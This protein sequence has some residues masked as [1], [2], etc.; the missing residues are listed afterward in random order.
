VP[1]ALRQVFA[2]SGVLA[3]E[4]G[5]KE[6]VTIRPGKRAWWVEPTAGGG[7]AEQPIEPRLI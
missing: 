3:A 7:Y 1:S 2:Y 4:P 5:Q 6:A